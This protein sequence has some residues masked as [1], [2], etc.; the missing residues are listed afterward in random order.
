MTTTNKVHYCP[1]PPYK[2]LTVT[3]TCLAVGF[4]IVTVTKDGERVWEGDDETV[5]LYHFEKLARKD[6]GEWKVEFYGPLSG[7]TYKRVGLNNW[8]LESKNGGFA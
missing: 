7:Q 1:P 6:P 5:M 4:G 3:K 8:E 2:T